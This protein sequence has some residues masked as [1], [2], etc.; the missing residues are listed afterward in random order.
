MGPENGGQNFT[1]RQFF[2]M[3]A[4]FHQLF[5]IPWIHS[6][7][8]TSNYAA[9]FHHWLQSDIKKI[10]LPPYTVPAS[11]I[12]RPYNVGSCPLSVCVAFL[13]ASFSVKMRKIVVRLVCIR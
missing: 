13:L 11:V 7:I 5:C 9:T 10:S 3:A 2:F 8:P 1:R 4:E 12:L 6:C